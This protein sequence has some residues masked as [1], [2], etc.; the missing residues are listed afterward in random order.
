M[1]KLYVMD[2]TVIVQLALKRTENKKSFSMLLKCGGS[3]LNL[4]VA[5]TK[6]LF[7]KRGGCGLVIIYIPFEL[8]T[9]CSN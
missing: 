2:V 1:Q 9:A 6:Y 8:K 7:Y 5:S 4:L 3:P